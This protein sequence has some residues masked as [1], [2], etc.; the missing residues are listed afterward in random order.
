MS[1]LWDG[2]LIM[3]GGQ[4][5]RMRQSGA[6][7]PKPL[8]E[9]AGVALIERN[10]Q[11]L[12][13]HGIR[14]IFVSVSADADAIRAF[15]ETRLM[16]L[17][18]CCGAR[19]EIL[20]ETRALGNIGA[21]RL[22][23]P[24]MQSTLVVYADNLSTLD[25]AAMARHHHDAGR[26]MTVAT[27]AEPFRMPYGEVSLAADGGL[28]AYTEKPVRQVMVCSAFAVVSPEACRQVPEARAFGISELCRALIAA[29]PG[30]TGFAHQAPWIDVNDLGDVARA[31]DLVAATPGFDLWA[32]PQVRRQEVAF[33]SAG[34][35]LRA[36]EGDVPPSA[37]PVVDH[38][39]AG[40]RA[41][42]RGYVLPPE[43][44]AGAAE[45]RGRSAGIVR[46]LRRLLDSGGLSARR[47]AAPLP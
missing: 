30:V 2:A 35:I 12:L 38:V 5:S 44:G 11:Q 6:D 23:P 9:V 3:A 21:I 24:E 39:P 29:G 22:L 10:L 45:D 40:T 27:H 33:A 16:D 18:Q 36:L 26:P 47:A 13:K 31:E 25:L 8:V 42:C 43:G 28:L 19:L 15:V 17:A 7:R 1:A 46:Q 20:T 37:R 32:P 14:R 41:L 4:G 34:G